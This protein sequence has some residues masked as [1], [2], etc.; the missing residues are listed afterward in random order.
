[1]AVQ[2]GMAS[3]AHNRWPAAAMAL[4]TLSVVAGIAAAGWWRL[5]P[6]AARTQN[7]AAEQ[8]RG[9]GRDNSRPSTGPALVQSGGDY[10]VHVKLIELRPVDTEGG[11]W[12]V[13]SEGA[14]DIYYTLF[15]NK[16]KVFES[17]EREDR[18]IAEWDLLR[19]DL[20]DAILS[21]QVEV[22][23]AVN[24]PLVRV[25]AG[26]MLTVE[27]FDEDVSFDDEAGRFDLPLE[28][29]RVGLNTLTPEGGGVARLVI[30]L[31]PRDTPLPDLL[32]RASNR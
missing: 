11:S 8:S 28:T 4:L 16:T 21:G 30:D 32:D 19:L 1:M 14:P 26:G 10:Y 20:K 24:G 5:Q 22:A 15:W 27:V 25:E 9:G 29:L 31:V 17:A 6:A 7:G 12:D 13:R 2:W 23:S 18:L 3:E